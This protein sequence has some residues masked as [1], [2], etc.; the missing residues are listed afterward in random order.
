MSSLINHNVSIITVKKD[1]KL[2]GMTC[3]WIMQCG[4]TELLALVGS[5]SVTGELIKENDIVGEAASVDVTRIEDII[6]WYG[7]RFQVNLGDI[8]NVDV[9]IAWMNTAIGQLSEYDRGI[10]DVS[11]TS[12]EDEVGFTPFVG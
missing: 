2:Y 4:Y 8:S 1:D 10:L 6:L 3:A 5:Q 11:F 12:W 9:K 7:T